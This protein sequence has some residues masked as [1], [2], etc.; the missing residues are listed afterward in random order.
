MPIDCARAGTRAITEC[1]RLCGAD[2][3][4]ANADPPEQPASTVNAEIAHSDRNGERR[5]IEAAS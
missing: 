5:R 1:E 3:F 2:N 4:G